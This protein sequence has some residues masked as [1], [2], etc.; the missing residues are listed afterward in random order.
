[1]SAGGGCAGEASGAA[2][3][4]A[5]GGGGGVVVP[6]AQRAQPAPGGEESAGAGRT[7]RHPLPRPGAR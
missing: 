1:M 7:H 4:G 2:P 3:A 5:A 6:G